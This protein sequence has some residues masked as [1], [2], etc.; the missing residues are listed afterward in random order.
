MRRCG[1]ALGARW[2]G[3]S[4]GVTLPIGSA[5]R[6]FAPT[7]SRCSGREI[8]W[9]RD[10]AHG[11]E[12]PTVWFRRI[13]Y[14]DFSRVGDHKAIWE[15]NRH[16]HLV[17]LAQA[18]RLTGRVVYLNEIAAELEHWMGCNPYGRGMQWTSA[19]EVAFRV[20]SW[21]WTWHL[22]GDVLP[23]PLRARWAKHFINMAYTCG[24]TCPW[25]FHRTPIC[26]ERR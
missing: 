16:Q 11:I 6:R 17:L 15:L 24:T 21:I 9:N 3:R 7:L 25:T 8:R 12:Y 18:W 26:W 19:L 10:Y 23:E 5:W 22:V 13:P 2:F 1:G 4:S 14:L 20:L